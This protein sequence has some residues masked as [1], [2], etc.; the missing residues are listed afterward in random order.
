MCLLDRKFK[1]III[2]LPLVCFPYQRSFRPDSVQVGRSNSNNRTVLEAS[3]LGPMVQGQFVV[4]NFGPSEIPAVQLD[5][6]W[7]AMFDD[8]NFIIYPSMIS[9]DSVEVSNVTSYVTKIKFVCVS[10][11]LYICIY[12]Y[13]Y[14]YYIYKPISLICLYI[15]N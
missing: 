11:V 15:L 1:Y 3:D 12:I 14:T 13:I 9:T 10:F 4:R 8:G 2:N 7:P 5:I 6:F